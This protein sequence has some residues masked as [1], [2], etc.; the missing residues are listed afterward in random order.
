MDVSIRRASL[1]DE[2]SFVPLMR[3]LYAH[4]GIPFDQEA[5]CAPLRELLADPSLGGAWLAFDGEDAAAYALATW[6]FSTEMG[7]R[8]LFLDELLVASPF[9]GRGLGSRFLALLEEFA[10]DGGAG[11]LRLEVSHENGRAR[12]LYLASGYT[13]PGRAFLAKRLAPRSRERG[14][15]PERVE[16]KVLVKAPPERVW[17][18]IAS[19]EGLDGWFTSGTTLD[20]R[21]GGRLAFRWERWGPD[22]FTGTFE[23][24]VL[25]A[26]RPR[27]F[28]FRWPVDSGTYETTVT[29][30][31]EP[32]DDGTL[33]RL[34]EHGF[35]EGPAGLRDMLSRSAG[36]G[37]ALA[38]MKLFVEHG[39]RA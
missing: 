36:W 22:A 13:D 31:L 5:L 21:P 38:L 6:G 8:F 37:E 1:A 7:G 15:R 39:V 34:S 27:R 14:L 32:R 28:S 30:D 16:T 35:E 3:A 17:Q 33:V 24:T 4:E 12:E 18:A 25:E 19:A 11:A 9:R 10:R 29:A 26:D 23:G 2:A 20:A